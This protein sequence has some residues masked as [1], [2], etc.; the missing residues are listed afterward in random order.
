MKQVWKSRD[1]AE[2]VGGCEAVVLLW[3]IPSPNTEEI[4][5]LLPEY[6]CSCFEAG[7]INP[8]EIKH[9]EE[10]DK[11]KCGGF[12]ISVHGNMYEQKD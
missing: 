3:Q 10:P 1:G 4:L 2:S 6:S 11:K 9:G 8:Y 12:L 5:S 7:I